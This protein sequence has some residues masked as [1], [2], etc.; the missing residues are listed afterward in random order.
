MNSSVL[1]VL[2][3][4]LLL[5]PL[6]A[7]GGG[8]GG[9]TPAPAA[10]AQRVDLTAG[11]EGDGAV[12]AVDVEIVLPE[13]FILEVD[14]S[15]QPTDTALAKLVEGGNMA[16]NYTPETEAT[17]GQLIIAIISASGFEPSA[18]LLKVS[19]IYAA[20]A[21]LPAADDFAISIEAFDL[22]GAA[23][24]ALSLITNL[25]ITPVP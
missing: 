22:D 24:P 23:M 11:L 14:D 16:V 2:A 21:S 1:K 6:L 12:G 10:V 5:I 3:L 18:D 20:G 19:R 17:N 4:V 7:C 13:G 9:D 25:T 8:G 15:G